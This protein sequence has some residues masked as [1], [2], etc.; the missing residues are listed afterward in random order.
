MSQASEDGATEESFRCPTCGAMFPT[1]EEDEGE[2]PI[3]GTHCTREACLV[4]FSSNE[5]F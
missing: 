5:D 4:L 3:D 2:C 1:N